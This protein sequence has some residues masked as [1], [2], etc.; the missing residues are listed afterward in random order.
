ML[1]AAGLGPDPVRAGR[2]VVGYTHAGRSTDVEARPRAV[3]DVELTQ[4][5]VGIPSPN[6]AR[7]DYR[8]T[9]DFYAACSC[10]DIERRPSTVTDVELV[11]ITVGPASV[12]AAVG[13]DG[14]VPSYAY[15]G[16]RGHVEARP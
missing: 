11:E 8:V 12:L 6:N 10:A 9:R 1:V 5:I 4:V 2:G 7:A 14:R 15:A 16:R 13:V 3:T